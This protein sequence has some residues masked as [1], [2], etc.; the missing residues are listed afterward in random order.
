MGRAAQQVAAAT[1]GGG[2][3]KARID[4]ETDL[5]APYDPDKIIQIGRAFMRIRENE[6]LS[7]MPPAEMGVTDRKNVERFGF[8]HGSGHAAWLAVG[9]CE[10]GYTQSRLGDARR[11]HLFE[12]RLMDRDDAPGIAAR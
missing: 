10:L 4:D 2:L 1:V 3:R 9:E 5:T 11:K 6:I 12:P 7:G 8:L